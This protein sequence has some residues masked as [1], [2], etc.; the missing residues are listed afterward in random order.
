[1]PITAGL[2][3][4][5]RSRLFTEQD[6]RA[7]YEALSSGQTAGYGTFKSAEAA[8][9][10]GNTLNKLVRNFYPDSQKWAGTVFAVTVTNEE[11]GEET[12]QYA[13]VLK[14]EKA[15]DAPPKKSSGRKR[16]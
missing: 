13:G 1:M 12:I 9:S 7:A 14:P 5:P 11:T 4:P 16:G 10:A 15:K 6:A 3:I 2:T 8:R